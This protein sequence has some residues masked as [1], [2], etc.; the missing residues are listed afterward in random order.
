MRVFIMTIALNKIFN[1]TDT[2]IKNSKIELNMKAGRDGES[3]L[4]RWLRRSETEKTMGYGTDWDCSFW[5]WYGHSRPNFRQGNW[6][7][8][9]ARLSSNEWLFISAAEIIEVPKNSWAKVRILDKFSPL[10]GR[11]IIECNKGNKFSLYTFKLNT[12]LDK[13]SVKEI[14]PSVYTGEKFEGYDKVHL[15][16]QKLE[17]IVNRKIM[18]TYYEALRKITGIYCLTDK[19]TGKLYIG[20]A[21]GEEGVAQRWGNYIDSKHGGNIELKKLYDEKKDIYFK[22]YF[23]FTLLEYF[24]LHYDPEKIKIRENYW[25]NCLNT[26]AKGYNDN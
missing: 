14:L 10:F 13:C 23:T 5:G 2:E 25:K 16:Y 26:R 17:D 4:D 24:G 9:F 3:F 8:S 19:K 20:S 1:L 21:T 7:F 15:S 18:P 6:V 12:F 22:K 11:L